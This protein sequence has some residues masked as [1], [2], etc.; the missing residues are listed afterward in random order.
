[1]ERRDR[2]DRRDGERGHASLE[3]LILLPFFFLVW[4]CIFFVHKAESHKAGVSMATR[5]CAWQ[6]MSGGCSGGGPP[7]CQLSAGPDQLGDEDLVGSSAALANVDALFPALAI[8]FRTMF[9]PSFRP[10]FGAER[11]LRVARPRV[12][13]GGETRVGAAFTG[14][15]NETGGHETLGSVSTE[16]FCE[17][18]GW[19]P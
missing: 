11:H 18:T 17:L 13:G 14:M 7:A 4:G 15:C 3:A 12:L 16:T 9:G 6:R 19:C 8:Q 5:S 2:R 1:M 10:V